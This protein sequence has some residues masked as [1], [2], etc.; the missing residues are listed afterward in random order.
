MR[1]CKF[2]II[3]ALLELSDYHYQL[4]LIKNRNEPSRPNESN[5]VDMT[6]GAD[7]IGTR[8]RERKA[9]MASRGNGRKKPLAAI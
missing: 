2:L 6:Y 5:G 3:N 8:R 1:A 4:F 9:A 7:R